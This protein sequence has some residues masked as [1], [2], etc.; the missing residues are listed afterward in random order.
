M[1][2]W[3]DLSRLFLSV[4]LARN[5]RLK[6]VNILSLNKIDVA[7]KNSI[8]PKSVEWQ[9]LCNR[10]GARSAA[11]VNHIQGATYPT[12]IDEIDDLLGGGLP[13]RAL[14]E[15][16]AAQPSSGGSLVLNRLLESACKRAGY[17]A[18]VDTHDHFAPDMIPNKLILQHLYWVRCCS[19]E[20]TLRIS[21]ILS[22]DRN[23]ALLIIDLRQ[24]DIRTLANIPANRW[25]RFQRAIEKNGGTSVALTA[26]PVIPAATT[27]LEL[28]RTFHLSDLERT[29]D[30]LATELTIHPL[31]GGRGDRGGRGGHISEAL[32]RLA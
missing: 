7:L 22:N 2:R 23:F 27:R 31:R 4:L 24:A 30:Q 12:H 32:Q 21:D 15:I 11:E 1:L 17:A 19:T 26:Q 8:S 18:L 3:R 29:T 25:Y 13:C 10:L 16:V 5:Q 14:T 9:T 28:T 20:Q 6:I